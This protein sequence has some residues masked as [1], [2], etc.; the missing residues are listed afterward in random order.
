MSV[1]RPLCSAKTDHAS[2]TCLVMPLAWLKRV[3]DHGAADLELAAGIPM[4]QQRVRLR[5]RECSSG[6][7]NHGASGTATI[8]VESTVPQ[9]VRLRQLRL[10]LQLKTG[11]IDEGIVLLFS[12]GSPRPAAGDNINPT[13]LSP[14]PVE[15]RTV[16]MIY[17]LLLCSLR[18]SSTFHAPYTGKLASG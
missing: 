9:T 11:A 18:P 6:A 4:L 13:G 5:I 3:P 7:G 14:I 10:H 16:C 15:W 2:V 8:H 1:R 17:L 12:S